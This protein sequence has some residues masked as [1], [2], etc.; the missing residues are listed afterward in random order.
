MRQDTEAALKQFDVSTFGRGGIINKLEERLTPDETVIY[1]APT[2][3]TVTTTATRK[4][5]KLPGAI[6]PRTPPRRHSSS[7]HVRRSQR[8]QRPRTRLRRQRA[9]LPFGRTPPRRAPSEP[10]QRLRALAAT[11]TRSGPSAKAYGPKHSCSPGSW[12]R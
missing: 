8:P 5:E 6:A 12:Q 4:T 9:T 7:T 1:I 3:V 2:N 10:G 11:W